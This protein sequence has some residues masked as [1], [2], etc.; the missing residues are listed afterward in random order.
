LFT[1]L[2]LLPSMATIASEKSFK[3]RHRTM[4]SRHTLRIA[5]PLSLRKSAIVLVRHQSARKPNQFDVT[6]RLALQS[7]ARLDSVQVTVDIDL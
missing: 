4:N 3:L 1:A 7:P 5:L 6:L 2:N